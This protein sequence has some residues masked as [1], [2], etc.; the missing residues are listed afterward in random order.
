MSNIEEI[1]AWK[2]K[3]HPVIASKAEEFQ[4]YGYETVTPDEIWQCV[5]EK[6]ERRIGD[7]K[8]HQLVAEIFRL[9]VNEY[10]NWL[11]I[12]AVTE[13]DFDI[14]KEENHRLLGLDDNEIT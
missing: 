12:R 4:L 14:R 1:K 11:T 2:N 5:L 9:S 10:M 8:L 7:Y 3:V 6:I 13:T